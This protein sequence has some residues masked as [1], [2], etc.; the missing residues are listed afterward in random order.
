MPLLWP[1]LASWFGGA[2]N[3]RRLSANKICTFHVKSCVPTPPGA[4]LW[5]RDVRRAKLEK[6]IFAPIAGSTVLTGGSFVR[7]EWATRSD[8]SFGLFVPQRG[9]GINACGAQCRPEAGLQA[10]NQQ[11]HDDYRE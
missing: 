11:H 4:P 9:S 7:D 10:D 3:S 2:Y 1:L 8:Y 5:L 6:K